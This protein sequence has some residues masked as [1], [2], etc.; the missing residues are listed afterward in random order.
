M[1]PSDPDRNH[2]DND[3]SRTAD[4]K[5]RRRRTEEKI[6]FQARMLNAVGEA[7]IA[8]DVEGKVIYWNRAAEKIYG[9]SAEEMIGRTLVEILISEDLREQAAEIRSAL[10]EGKPWSGEFTVQR[11][12]GTS[13]PV[14]VTDTPVHDDQGNVVGLIG[15]STDITE[16][17]RA[18]AKLKESER[19]FSTLLSNT[20]AMVYRCLNEPDWPE[21]YVSDYALELTGYPAA[22]FM[23]NPTLFGSLIFERDKQRIWDE[24]Q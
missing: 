23:K 15:V 20:P 1:N 22:E 5:S 11:K 21:E 14:H 24:I 12:D 16:R 9:W 13:F 6:L 7:I 10:R 2:L 8:T 3:V 19:R 4:K 18:E 17:K